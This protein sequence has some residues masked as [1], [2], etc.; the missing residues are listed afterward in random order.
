MSP[1]TL[2]PSRF[3]PGSIVRARGREWVV[4][5][6][7]DAELLVLRPLGG[8]DDEVTGLDLAF[9]GD[10]VKPARFE[11]P[12]VADLGDHARA[13]LLQQAL[14]LSIR[15]GAGPFRSFGRI[16][17]EP[18]PYQLVP[19]LMGLR[20]D[21][22]RL[23]I[24]DD[25]GIGKTVE[26]LLIARELLDRGEIDRF[27]VLTPPHLADQWRTEMRDKFHIDAAVVL[28]STVARLE[29]GLRLS[30]SVFEH[31]RFVIV[32]MDFIKSERH[33]AE[34]L[35]TAPDLVI[36]D[37]AH[38]CADTSAGRS[39]RHL[40]AALVRK[41]ADRVDRH[42]L[43]VTATPH[44]GNEAAFR[45]LLGYLDLDFAAL[46]DDL[47]GPANEHVRRRL[48]RHLVQRRRVDIKAYL[49]TATPFPERL[50]QD[51]TYEL[52][53]SYEAFFH[54]VLAYARETVRDRTG[55]AQRQR[56]RW[57]S[58][59]ALLR[60][61]GSSPA[62]AAAT[63]RERNRTAEAADAAEVEAIGRMGV[64]DLEDETLEGSDVTPGADP[65]E[66]EEVRRD[67]TRAR[68]LRLAKEADALAGKEDAKLTRGVAVVR[69]LLDE[70]MSPIVFCRFIATA[71]YVKDALRV[72]LPN[73]V[74]VEAVTGTLPADARQDRVQA[75][76]HEPRRVLVATDCLSEGINLQE[77]FDAV[78]HYDLSWNPTRHEQREGRVDRY[79]QRRSEVKIVTLYG[80]D[81]PI[82]GIV[83][84]VLLRKH[85]VIRESTG[86]SVPV[87]ID[88]N[89]VLE[90]I[91]EGILIR[92]SDDDSRADQL[93]FWERE[94]IDPGRRE[95]FAE[96]DRAAE[97]EK[98]SRTLFAQLGFPLGEVIRA[99]DEARVAVGSGIDVK[100]FAI[101]A[102]V[103]H[104]ATASERSDGG[105]DV[106]LGGL[107]RAIRDLI[108][109]DNGER[110]R[111][112]FEPPVR[113]TE[114]LVGRTHPIIAGLADHLI[115]TALDP[116]GGGIARRAGAIR[117]SGVSVRHT[118]LLLRMRFDVRSRTSRD[119]EHVGLA[120]EV[121]VAAFRG[122]PGSPEWL[123]A[124]EAD[125]LLD[126]APTANIISD[127]ARD[128]IERVTSGF[129]ALVP[130]LDRLAAARAADLE[131]EHQRVRDIAALTARTSV[132]PQLPI[133]VLGIYALLPAPK[134]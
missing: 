28:P 34:F 58:A 20:L 122:D 83:L 125:R 71:E 110:M 31:N 121:R 35:R 88:S 2:S 131:G 109:I 98:R 86:I 19:L 45:A 85:R 107:P 27:A 84:S 105:V 42:L 5:P 113:E 91:L 130:A 52:T 69:K 61:V 48:A 132:T 47:S 46:P 94:V 41:L 77:G 112:R 50:T 106:D 4:L 81:N 92:G 74:V 123:T 63:L 13:R 96:W 54:R 37:E 126:V 60:A 134:A 22:V 79:G 44:S 53:P 124:E 10:D 111:L 59:L 93:S 32:S 119:G 15:D 38:T 62:A 11:P 7:S 39:G 18:R 30:E 101:D 26:A 29:R 21:P 3:T 89:K 104:N 70:G 120:E 128:A 73:D 33:R 57:W 76:A 133:D 102:L 16:A 97:R 78:V 40:R 24:A 116:L 115:D 8:S 118:V 36:V 103:A 65:V 25:V 1:F 14:R 127:Q 75:L 100:R 117:T 43:L 80:S 51:A 66:G 99:R 17:V 114:T 56:V 12:T 68:L 23:L 95:L 72:A 129:D 64:L 49:D 108:A 90:A 67:A 9:E 87:P 6:D 82:D 55:S